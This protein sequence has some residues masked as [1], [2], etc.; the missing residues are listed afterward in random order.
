MGLFLVEMSGAQAVSKPI[1]QIEL[2][3]G[4][5]DQILES[6]KAKVKNSSVRLLLA[7]ECCYFFVKP[8]PKPQTSTPQLRAQVQ[9]LAQKS[10]PEILSEVDWDFQ[11]SQA[12]GP[13]D[14]LLVYA[15]M[16]SYY[17]PWKTAA[18]K[19]NLTVEAVEFDSQALARNSDAVVGLALKKDISGQDAQVL[20]LATSIKK[21]AHHV[22]YWIIF[23][24]IALII[25]FTAIAGVFWWLKLA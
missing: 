24:T 12:E 20:N 16:S 18:A 14:R 13:Y 11:I 15:P 2:Q 8:W 21:S 7:D 10:I 5:F 9:E 22:L 23:L 6:I 19:Y 25:I 3:A 17:V 4:S 1:L